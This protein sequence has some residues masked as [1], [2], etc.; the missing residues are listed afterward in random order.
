MPNTAGAK[1]TVVGGAIVSDELEC[2]QGGQDLVRA[3]MPELGYAR[4]K[5]DR[6][7]VVVLHPHLLWTHTAWRS[8]RHS[9]GRAH[10][11]VTL[12]R[13]KRSGMPYPEPVRYTG[14]VF[15]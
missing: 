3:S 10:R 5:L 14:H 4:D 12:Y 9:P 15:L 13:Q 11:L 8:T 1:L 6:H 7:N 2:Q